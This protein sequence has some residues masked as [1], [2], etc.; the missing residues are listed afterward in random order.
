MYRFSYGDGGDVTVDL[1][2]DGGT[3]QPKSKAKQAKQAVRG[4]RVCRQSCWITRKLCR[5]GTLLV[6]NNINNMKR[7][8]CRAWMCPT[9][10][11]RSSA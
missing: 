3:K 11:I 9:C 1:G 10:S 5:G 8:Y 7:T 6:A 4:V 2:L